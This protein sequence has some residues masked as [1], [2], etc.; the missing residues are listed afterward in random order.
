MKSKCGS[1]DSSISTMFS[2]GL[3]QNLWIMSQNPCIT[4][5]NINITIINILNH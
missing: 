3:I 4:H 1:T 2:N 5:N